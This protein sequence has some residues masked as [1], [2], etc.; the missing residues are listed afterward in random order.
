M[1]AMRRAARSSGGVLVAVTAITGLVASIGASQAQLASLQ[2]GEELAEKL[3]SS[4]HIVG[5]EAASD[6]VSADV[7]SFA[8][9]ANKPG[10]T[11]E[12]I[13]GRIVIPHPAMPDIQL[14]RLEIADLTAYIL[15]LRD[16]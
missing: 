12:I 8:E 16:S 6:S 4:C 10:Q 13:A 14:T 2:M 1:G 9:I 15:S 3:C 5:K 11:A 7:P